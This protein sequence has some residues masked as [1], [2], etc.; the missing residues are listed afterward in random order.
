V[1]RDDV[2]YVLTRAVG[3]RHV[4]PL[5]IAVFVVVDEDFVAIAF[6]VFNFFPVAALLAIIGPITATVSV[7]GANKD[8]R[9]TT[10]LVV[11]NRAAVGWSGSG[12][13]DNGKSGK[14]CNCNKR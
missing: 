14:K 8:S 6:D 7:S 3:I 2:S 9:F 1:R 10:A 13:G 12:I 11:V 5:T 4:D